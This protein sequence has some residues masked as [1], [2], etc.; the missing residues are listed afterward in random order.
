MGVFMMGKSG[1]ALLKGGA[2]ISVLVLILATGT[3][4]AGALPGQGHFA[5]GRGSIAKANG[6]MTVD[7]SSRLGII[8]WKNFSVGKANGISFQNGHGATLNIVAGGNISRIAGHLQGTGSVYLINRAGVAITGHGRIDTQGTFA[9]SS[10]NADL[11]SFGNGKRLLFAGRGKGNVID[12]GAITASNVSLV[13]GSRLNV[14]GSVAAKGRVETSGARIGG[15]SGASISARN[16]LIDPRNLKVTS[17][18][19]G[20]ISSSLNGGS[21]VTLQTSSSSCGGP[22][23]CSS[24]PGNITI[25]APISW[26]STARLTLD[27]YRSVNIDNSIHAKGKGDLTIMTAHGGDLFFG[28]GSATFDFLSSDLTIDGHSYTLEKNITGLSNDIATHPSGHFALANDFNA[29][30]HTYSSSPIDTLFAG[31]FEGLGH[32]ISHFTLYASG[33]HAG[34]FRSADT[35]SALRDVTL[36]GADV[37]GLEDNSYVGA[38]VAYTKGDIAGV[39]VSGNVTGGY[40]AYMG[41]VAGYISGAGSISNSSSSALIQGGDGGYVGGLVGEDNGFATA[42]SASGDVEAGYDYGYVGGLIGYAQGPVTNAHASGQVKAD[43]G[44][45]GGL[46]GYTN[47]KV[48][49][50]H[51]TGDVY[52]GYDSY[53][54][55][56]VGYN[57][58]G[59][60]TN[61][62]ATGDVF[63]DDDDYIGGLIGYD[64]AGTVKSSHATG[65]VNGEYDGYAGGLIGYSD[66]DSVGNS[67]ATGGVFSDDDYAGGLIGYADTTAINK[68]HAKG[69]VTGGYDTYVGGLVGYV[70]Q[71]SPITNSYATGNVKSGE[72]GYVGGLVGEIADTASPI[73]N[74][75]ASGNVSVGYEYYAGGLVGYNDG[76]LLDTVY[77][78]GN[79]TGGYESYNGGLVGENYGTI[80]DSY[81]TGKVQGGYEGSTGGLVGEQAAKGITGSH[82]KG[83]VLAGDSSDVGGLVGYWHSSGTLKNSHATGT[84]YGGESAYAGG[85]AGYVDAGTVQNTYA[86]GDVTS[87]Y[88]GGAGGLIGEN[89]AGAIE[90]SYATG[91]VYAGYDSYG[92][93]LIGYQTGGSTDQSFATGHVTGSGADLGGLVGYNLNG[94]VTN[95]YA[96]GEI[97]GDGASDVG[98]FIGYNTGGTVAKSYSTGLVSGGTVGGFLGYYNSGTFNSNYWDKSQSGT[99]TGVGTGSPGGIAGKAT[100]F[101]K[102]VPGSWNNSIWKVSSGVNGGLLHLKN[103]PPP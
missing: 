8:D 52:A 44:E 103:N 13:A 86:T 55:G 48:A 77:A 61:T 71:L 23:T 3:A 45:I 24:G 38:L 70:V 46:L 74:S 80:K 72:E 51:A 75:H 31:T 30:G 37:N 59:K 33:T 41:G 82:A 36:T 14:T 73:S 43:Y 90:L 89:S 91:E 95:S 42:V 84:V 65:N 98:G 49:D 60:I 94:D 19:A 99:N 47:A 93:G 68:S 11:D 87:A 32:T 12:R 83:N 62:Y 10:R 21:N 64:D 53:A 56:L 40:E 1:L 27:A 54:G 18:A 57:D 29:G 35:G 67:Y 63:S 50:S 15:L 28:N 5:Q 17:G 92:G 97:D 78:T 88:D 102:S 76:S 34:L 81:A 25:A 58:G 16:W 79:V 6:R 7:Q 85:L 100:S 66:S 69:N 2:S 39:R 22:G 20:T 4:E 96:R 101:F 26:N 9:A